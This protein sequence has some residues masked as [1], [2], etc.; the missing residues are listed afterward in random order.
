MNENGIMFYMHVRFRFI[1]LI[2][3]LPLATIGRDFPAME[4]FEDAFEKV[5]QC[6]KFYQSNSEK[7][8]Q[9]IYALWFDTQS[10]RHPENGITTQIA[11]QNPRSIDSLTDVS[12][13][14]WKKN[15]SDFQHL[16]RNI[17]DNVYQATLNTKHQAIEIIE[18]TNYVALVNPVN[19]MRY[20]ASNAQIV[21]GLIY[22]DRRVYTIVIN[23]THNDANHVKCLFEKCVKHLTLTGGGRRLSLDFVA[24]LNESR[25]DK[26]W[27]SVNYAKAE[28]IELQ[29]DIPDILKEGKTFQPHTVAS[30]G[31][32]DT[33]SSYS[34]HLHISI[35]PTDETLETIIRCL[36]KNVQIDK[37]LLENYIP[38]S[39]KVVTCGSYDK[40][41]VPIL[42]VVLD[43]NATI[44][45]LKV[46]QRQKMFFIPSKMGKIVQVVFGLFS[47]DDAFDSNAFSALDLTI[48]RVMNSLTFLHPSQ[49]SN[50]LP[51][52]ASCGTAWF[53]ASNLLVTCWH[54]VGLAQ[55]ISFTTPTSEKI[56]CTVIARDECAD[57]ALLKAPYISDITLPIGEDANIADDVFALGYP[58]PE[59]M[60]RSIKYTEGSISSLSGLH[61]NQ[62]LYQLSVPLQPGN[63]GGPVFSN[64]G[65]VI[66]V[67]RSRLETALV[68]SVTAREAQN[69]NY[70]IKASVLR[71]FL[72]K[73]NV[74]LQLE[75]SNLN[76]SKSEIV[77]HVQPA[78]VLLM[79]K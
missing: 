26:R 14:L 22:L 1:L 19:L 50:T 33:A 72:N 15:K 42:Y 5:S 12:P 66:G 11:I 47:K 18:G 73:H 3:L 28:G 68:E 25:S 34:V 78:V 21:I 2:A 46:R 51:N 58:N 16:M 40:G 74:E 53:V 69:V 23:D 39:A 32:T 9:V 49:F 54:V 43:S 29:L 62:Q 38:G 13:D 45:G 61:D 44:P 41:G 37:E 10:C 35:N 55:E 36:N 27:T 70:A 7:K 76:C 67:A 52:A 24:H 65:S 31:A 60:G 8:G 48:Q 63:S 79:I 57:L 6:A 20:S 59:V 71:D 30:F 4:G 75:Q 64:N 77:K 17:D 56:V